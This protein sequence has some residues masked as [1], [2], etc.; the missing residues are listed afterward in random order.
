MDNSFPLI[1][2]TA[3]ERKALTA[4]RE[5][6]GALFDRYKPYLPR[7]LE[8]RR[9]A[10][11]V[12]WPNPFYGSHEGMVEFETVDAVKHSGDGGKAAYYR[13]KL[14][15]DLETAPGILAILDR[16]DK[17]AADAETVLRE[18]VRELSAQ[19]PEGVPAPAVPEAHPILARRRL[20]ARRREEVNE[21]R[22]SDVFATL[23]GVAESLS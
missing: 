5:K 18:Q 15:I 2:P 21:R 22:Y 13:A 11:R 14:Q 8:E 1:K 16:A 17:A 19:L 9:R 12:G 6:L 7:A 10:A 20:I 3:E 4:A 23:E